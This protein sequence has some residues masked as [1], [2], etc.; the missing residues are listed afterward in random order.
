MERKGEANGGRRGVT[1]VEFILMVGL[2]VF[3]VIIVVNFGIHNLFN[4][5][6]NQ[7]NATNTQL[8]K[9][10]ACFFVDCADTCDP[11]GLIQLNSPICVNGAC[12]Y[13]G[14]KYCGGGP[15]V[16]GVCVDPRPFANFTANTSGGI[17][18]MQFQDYD[19]DT[20]PGFVT[21]RQW[22][23]GDG[24]VSTY[25]TRFTVQHYFRVPGF[26]NVTHTAVDNAGQSN[27]TTAWKVWAP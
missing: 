2:S 17:E 10:Q 8:G 18:P 22:D 15:C 26:Y 21:T 12:V 4:P 13:R 9:Q 25:Y 16:N 6:M 7:S 24:N 3:I 19:G 27:S 1:A 11:T 20:S 23:F 5:S 14:S